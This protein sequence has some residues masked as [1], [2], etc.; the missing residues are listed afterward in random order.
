M[1]RCNECLGIFNDEEGVGY[2]TNGD[3]V[4]IDEDSMEHNMHNP[5]YCVK[6]LCHECDYEKY[7]IEEGK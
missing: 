4:A 2:N 1:F 5:D 6:I 3:S 7:I